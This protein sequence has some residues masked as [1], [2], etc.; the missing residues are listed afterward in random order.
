[1]LIQNVLIYF[2]LIGITGEQICLGFKKTD[3]RKLPEW[4]TKT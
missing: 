4:P 3:I 1:M 2:I